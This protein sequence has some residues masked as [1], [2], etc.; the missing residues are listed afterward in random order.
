[1]DRE[2]ETRVDSE[3]HVPIPRE[4]RD[5]HGMSNGARVKVAERGAE[6]IIT[7]VSNVGGAIPGKRRS[8]SDLVGFLGKDPKSLR[9]LMDERRKDREKEDSPLGS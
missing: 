2:F 4:I 1:M 3:G 5:R 7:P 6:V 9:T 8:M